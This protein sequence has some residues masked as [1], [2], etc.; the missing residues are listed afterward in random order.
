[1]T[2]QQDNALKLAKLAKIMRLMLNQ[3]DT[4]Y[5]YT[6]LYSWVTLRR[7]I[8]VPGKC[9]DFK[10]H[11]YAVDIYKDTSQILI[12]KKASQL[13]ASEYLITYS[14]HMCD[15]RGGNVLY[16]FPTLGHVSDF[17][18]A[19]LGPAIEASE[20][21][22]SIV[23]E[24]RGK[25]EKRGVDRIT[26]KRIRDRFLY[27]RSS[28][29]SP[30]GL[31]PALKSIDAD[32]LIVDEVDE[33]DSRAVPIARKRLGHSVIAEERLV[34]TPTYPDVGIDT[35]WIESDQ[36]E[37]M[38]PCES[39]GTRQ[40]VTIKHIVTDWDSLERPVAWHGQSEG[41]A[42]PACEKCGKQLNRLARGEWIPRFPGRAVVGYHPTK[43]ISPIVDLLQIVNN[44]NTTNETK[45]REAYN[46]DL[47]ETYTPRGGQM[48]AEVLDECRRDYGH[49]PIARD[50]PYLGAD[51]GSVL[52]V[53]IR[54]GQDRTTGEYTQRFA[55]EVES[56]EELGRLMR[57]FK[58]RRAV[59]D[60]A[61]ETKKAR[62]FQASFPPGV[63][64]LAYYLDD[65]KRESSLTWKEDE[66]VVD[67]DRTWSLDEMYARFYEG[68]NTLPAN[69]RDIPDYYDHLTAPVRV[70]EEKK[71]GHKVAR[72]VE[73]RPDHL[74][75]AENYCRA[76]MFA[77]ATK[78]VGKS[79]SVKIEM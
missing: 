41:T 19:R 37:W 74:A 47:G 36:R 52:H 8:L 27:F 24:S 22:Q 23:V 78:A 77:P 67:M 17:S 66:G 75:H 59:L 21:L 57:K 48:T 4:S 42:W 63:V 18:S 2:V 11:S 6:P 58:V 3:D 30:S 7:P 10:N 70:L 64:W 65:S 13:F 9:L 55:G 62:E 69:A 76:A 15:E 34:S 56:F 38:I 29:V 20:Y 16:V 31:A 14:L 44:L 28:L 45:R 60:A 39:C 72:Y 5:G 73:S 33:C 71:M 26:L 25:Q 32:A 79:R 53:V 54:S 49:G 61:P 12:I 46:Q 68:F 35:L 43:L 40:V 51:V 50:E 1:M